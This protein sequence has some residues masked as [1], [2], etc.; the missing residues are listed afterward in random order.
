MRNSALRFS[1]SINSTFNMAQLHD[2]SFT[3]AGDPSLQAKGTIGSG[4]HGAVYKVTAS[5]PIVML[6]IDL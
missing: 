6:I 3:T 4:G 2:Q 1:T 5:D